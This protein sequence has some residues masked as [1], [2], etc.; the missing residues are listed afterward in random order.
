[1]SLERYDKLPPQVGESKRDYALRLQEIGH[2]EMFMRKALAYHFHVE[3]SEFS[4]FFN[5]FELARL[6]H[7]SMLRL[8]FPNRNNYSLIKKVSKNLG[9]SDELAELWVAR[10]NE[11]GEVT[12]IGID[13]LRSK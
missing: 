1:M 11:V 9:I 3:I 8:L 7:I 5:A 6:R 10:H 4:A 13:D 2:E 12:F